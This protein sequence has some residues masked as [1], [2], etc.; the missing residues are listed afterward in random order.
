MLTLIGLGLFDEK[1]LTLKGLEEAKNADKLYVELY[2]SYWH[3]NLK[4]L[5][6]FTKIFIFSNRINFYIMSIF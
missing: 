4:N 3:G 1:D 2:T 6:I 5:E